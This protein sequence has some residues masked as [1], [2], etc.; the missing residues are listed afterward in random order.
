M[1]QVAVLP[2]P[3]EATQLGLGRRVQIGAKFPMEL[4]WVWRQRAQARLQGGAWN[5]SHGKAVSLPVS[6]SPFT[7]RHTENA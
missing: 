2:V 1:A 7:V 3:T 5:V 6:S 4:G